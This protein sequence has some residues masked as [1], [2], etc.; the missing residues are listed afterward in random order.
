ML[1]PNFCSTFVILLLCPPFVFFFGTDVL[2]GHATSQER[3]KEQHQKDHMSRVLRLGRVT[4]ADRAT[5]K[6]N[7]FRGLLEDSVRVFLVAC[8][9]DALRNLEAMSRSL[10]FTCN[11]SNYRKNDVYPRPQ[12]LVD[13][14]IASLSAPSCSSFEQV[15][16]CFA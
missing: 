11:P 3:E 6:P 1:Q 12:G 16:A 15:F 13:R 5:R 4:K 10:A 14:I 9:R 8:A 7:L 2:T